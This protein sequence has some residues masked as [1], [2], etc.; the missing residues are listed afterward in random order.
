ME[1]T[2]VTSAAD[3]ACTISV[4]RTAGEAPTAFS[5][6]LKNKEEVELW[7]RR[8]QAALLCPYLTADSFKA[9]SGDEIKELTDR[10]R[11]P[12][13]LTVSPGKVVIDIMDPDGADLAFIDLPGRSSKNC[14]HPACQ[15]ETPVQGSYTTRATR[16]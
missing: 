15:A 14:P 9:R 2:I 6:E 4:R 1:C 16:S 11:H 8:A 7:I 13:V 12:E 5:H 3:W 10:N